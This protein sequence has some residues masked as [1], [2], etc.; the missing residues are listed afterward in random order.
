MIYT[1]KTLK[2][3]KL[4][5]N[6]NTDLFYLTRTPMI[7]MNFGVVSNVT[8]QSFDQLF[9]LYPNPTKEV[10][11]ISLNEKE[12]ALLEMFDQAGRRIHSQTFNLEQTKIEM[13]L[14]SFA[15][16]IY[17]LRVTQND[18]SSSQIFIKQ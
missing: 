8:E 5:N 7:R 15:A 4:F 2:N 9:Q 11:S 16:G 3:Y 10:I 17:M 1:K 18:H 13:N 12:S 14:A 6:S